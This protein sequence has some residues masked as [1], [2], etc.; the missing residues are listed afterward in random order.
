[1]YCSSMMPFD[2]YDKDDLSILLERDMFSCSLDI[3]KL[4]FPPT[5]VRDPTPSVHSK[6]DSKGVRL[7]KID[8]PKFHGN[9]INWST[10]WEQFDISVHT[11]LTQHLLKDGM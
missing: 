4:L 6:V 3:K 9:I 10:F 8:V 1:M 2:L 7:P 5:P 11:L